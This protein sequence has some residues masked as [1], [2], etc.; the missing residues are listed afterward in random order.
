MASYNM[1]QETFKDAAQVFHWATKRHFELW[2]TGAAPKRHRRTEMVLKKL[3]DKG[4]LRA[5]RYGRQLIYSLPRKG[6]LALVRHGLACT[7]CLVRFYRSSLDSTVIPERFFRGMGSVPDG[8]ILF[9]NGKILLLE[10]C[11]RDNFLFSGLIRAKLA[12]Y[13]KNISKI[14]VKFNAEAIVVFV[15]DVGPHELKVDLQGSHGPYY[16][17]D[18]ETF[19]KVPIGQQLSAPIYLWTDGKTYPLKNG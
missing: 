16:F 18:Y 10:F 13:D 8:G 9:R 15:A 14:E 5:I 3:V 12:A 2:F 7:E 19:L 6:S 17:T 1:F 11:T 4:R